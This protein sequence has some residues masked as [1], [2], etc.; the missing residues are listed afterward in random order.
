MGYQKKGSNDQLYNWISRKAMKLST[1]RLL[2]SLLVSVPLMLRPNIPILQQIVHFA[3]VFL[4][5]NL[6][7]KTHKKKCSNNNNNPGSLF[8]DLRHDFGGQ[9]VKVVSKLPDSIRGEVQHI[10]LESL[11]AEL[12]HLRQNLAMFSF[13]CIPP[14]CQF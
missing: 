6:E 1:S 14:A 11:A 2:G 13:W 8:L 3:I 10:R 9:N 12:S 5:S 4:L 7:T